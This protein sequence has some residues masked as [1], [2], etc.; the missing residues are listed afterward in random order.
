M[1]ASFDGE[2][3]NRQ[4][5]VVDHIQKPIQMFLIL[6]R[7]HDQQNP[8]AFSCHP[9]VVQALTYRL[10]PFPRKVNLHRVGVQNTVHTGP[11][12][13]PDLGPPVL[14]FAPLALI[15]GLRLLRKT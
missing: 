3:I 1:G 7:E 9:G 2:N 8:G 14:R 4:V 6:G 13:E 10:R 15:M 5:E 11:V 12:G